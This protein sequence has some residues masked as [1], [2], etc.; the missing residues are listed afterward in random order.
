MSEK[1]LGIDVS[2]WQDVNSTPQTMDFNKA[3]AAGAQFAFI[4]ASQQLFKDEDIVINWQNAKAAGLLRGAYHF[5]TWDKPA[6]DQAR[7]FWSVIQQDPG[8]LPPVCDFEWWNG[9][10]PS[11]GY[12]ML[13]DFLTELK[14]LC[15][16][17]P[18]IYTGYYVWVDYGR[19]DAAWAQF[20][21]WLAFYGAEAVMKIP[22]PWTR[23][24]FW[25]YTSKGDGL[26]FGAESLSLDMDYFN[27]SYADL[28]TFAGIN[29]PE[30]TPQPTLESRVSSLEAVTTLLLEQVGELEKLHETQPYHVHL[31]S[32]QK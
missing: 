10:I 9:A 25:Q 20:P 29:Q 24:T 22:P 31:P 18:M 14:L 11:Y 26:K 19:K 5:L 21:L 6:K 15:G 17:T 27:G 7:F 4:K 23:F 2:K 1:V 30:P 8:E 16:R 3:K 28:L 12:S 32:I 13:W